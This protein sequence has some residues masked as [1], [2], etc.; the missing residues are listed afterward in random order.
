MFLNVLSLQNK[1]IFLSHKNPCFQ[2]SI[3]IMNFLVSH[4]CEIGFHDAVDQST[5]HLHVFL[6]KNSKTMADLH[7]QMSMFWI[8]IFQLDSVM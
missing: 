1:D 7:G 8:L 5:V 6:H 3:A 4:T 2:C